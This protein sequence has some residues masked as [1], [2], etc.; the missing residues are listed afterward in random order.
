MLTYITNWYMFYIRNCQLHFDSYYLFVVYNT[1]D[2]CLNIHTLI[3]IN[4]I[5]ILL[6]YF[7]LLF[8][9]SI[10]VLQRPLL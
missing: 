7:F 4:I 9:S 3:S 5:S 1:I 10:T 8:C 6:P 2:R